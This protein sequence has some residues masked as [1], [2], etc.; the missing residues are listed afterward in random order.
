MAA[1]LVADL[2]K[3]S[4]R[5]RPEDPAANQIDEDE[6]SD[7][8]AAEVV[9]APFRFFDL[10]SE[11]RLKIYGFVLFSSKR[12]TSARPSG[13][14]GSSSKNKPLAPLSH[15]LSLF[16]ASRRLHDEAA[17]LFYSVQTFRV[18]P[19]QDYSRQPVLSSLGSSYRPMIGK[20]ELILGSSWTAPPK[21]WK[22]TSRLGLTQM[23][24]VKIFKIFIQCDPSHPVFEGFRISNDY[25]TGFAG[26][27][28][29]QILEQLPNLGHVEFDAWPSVQKN[30]AL[31][32]R[33]LSEV[34]AAGQKIYWGPER[35]WNDWEDDN[36]RISTG[37]EKPDSTSDH[38]GPKEVGAVPC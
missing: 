9:L 13:N 5:D 29:R 14:V 3:L 1:A 8:E 18:F 24:G 11:I 38:A 12:K 30:G 4:L 33:L 21:S 22:V 7:D 34:R 2:D 19:I 27:L 23:T 15:R 10:P 17:S 16:L 37:F 32:R 6:F 26:E 31:M 25:Y 35:G 28:V 20:I 36:D